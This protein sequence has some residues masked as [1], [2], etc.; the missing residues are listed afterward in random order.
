[1]NGLIAALFFRCDTKLNARYPDGYVVGAL[2]NPGGN[3]K[4][5]WRIFAPTARREIIRAHFFEVKF[6]KA[7]RAMCVSA[8][9]KVIH[10]TRGN[11]PLPESEDSRRRSG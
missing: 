3:S 1:M 4:P 9:R 7:F 5:A 2:G 6:N 8:Q 11:V 10:Q